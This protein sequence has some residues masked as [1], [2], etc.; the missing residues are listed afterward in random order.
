MYTILGVIGTMTE[1][2]SIDKI[3]D[4]FKWVIT[5]FYKIILIAFFGY[6]S[7]AGLISSATDLTTLKTTK[8]V[9]S[10]SVPIVGSII[11][12][13]SDAILSGA[14]VIK[15]SIGVFGFLGVCAICLIPF[16]KSLTGYIVFKVV[17][18][19]SGSFCN[20]TI[21]KVIDKV[22]DSYNLAL[23]SL[24]SCSA[25]LFIMIVVT[26]VVTYS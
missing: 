18:A 4:L 11:A 9:I 19:I 8:T 13:A 17:S 2:S 7:L 5:M 21:C 3:C 15:I 1:V 22:A 12:D 23:A 26:S 14:G 20:N 24:A 6:I 25:L 10:N 16:I